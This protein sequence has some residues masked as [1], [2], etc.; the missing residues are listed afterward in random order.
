MRRYVSNDG[1]H[2]NNPGNPAEYPKNSE[3]DPLWYLEMFAHYC[4]MIRQWSKPFALTAGPA[5]LRDYPVMTNSLDIVVWLAESDTSSKLEAWQGV[6][7]EGGSKKK[8]KT[9]TSLE[10]FP[11]QSGADMAPPT[12]Y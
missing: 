1:H 7:V 4:S 10:V 2:Q 11:V 5:T 6:V 3:W 8:T 12:D 9:M